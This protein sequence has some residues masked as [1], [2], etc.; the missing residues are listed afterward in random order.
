MNHI[1]L[2]PELIHL[3]NM[4][5]TIYSDVLGS[6]TQDFNNRGAERTAEFKPTKVNYYLGETCCSDREISILQ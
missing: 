3:L 4:S 6:E 1:S 5:H 2:L